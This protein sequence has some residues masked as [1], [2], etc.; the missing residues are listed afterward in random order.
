LVLILVAGLWTTRNAYREIRGAKRYYAQLVDSV[1]GHVEPGGYLLSNVWWLDQIAAD[2]YGT[3]T[4]LFTGTADTATTALRR[5]AEGGIDS[6]ALVWTVESD[7]ESL[8]AAVQGTCFREAARH[9]IE[10][11]QLVLI[12]VRCDGQER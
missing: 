8:A 4:F 12:V 7:G 6:A 11:R 2:L 10:E 3:R 5:M 9:A 1:A